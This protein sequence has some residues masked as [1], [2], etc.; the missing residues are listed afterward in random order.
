MRRSHLRV[1]DINTFESNSVERRI[2]DSA[3]HL[4]LD[5]ERSVLVGS[6][7]LVLYGVQ[8]PQVDALLD[9]SGET[10]RPKDIDFTV[11]A[12]YFIEL[13][14]NGQTPSGAPVEL[15]D[16]NANKQFTILTTKNHSPSHI[17]P[18]DLLTRYTADYGSVRQFDRGFQKHF[19]KHSTVIPGSNGL[20]IA[21]PDYLKMSLKSRSVDFKYLDDL[22]ALEA[23]EI[24]SRQK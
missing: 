3:E 23:H 12:S 6:A 1:P 20:R 16:D 5:P 24:R 22:R 15:L 9:P 10:V 19:R 17:L 14:K 2:V 7:A 21:T 11:N 13:H 18:A 8:L 4:G